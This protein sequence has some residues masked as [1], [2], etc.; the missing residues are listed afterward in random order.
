MT[1][2]DTASGRRK[3]RRSL[4]RLET[5]LFLV[6]AM[7]AETISSRHAPAGKASFHCTSKRLVG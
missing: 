6:S 4:G 7:V 2:L 3:L 5:V 1:V